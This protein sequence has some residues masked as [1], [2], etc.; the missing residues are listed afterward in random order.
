MVEI[1]DLAKTLFKEYC[2]GIITASV[3]NSSFDEG[4]WSEIDALT[5]EIRKKYSVADISTITN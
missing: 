2:A 3:K 5:E 1:S 4:L